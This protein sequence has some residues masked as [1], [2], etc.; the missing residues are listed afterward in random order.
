M[1]PLTDPA[2]SSALIAAIQWLQGALLGSVAI[3]T[4][5]ISVA[6]VGLLMLSGRI[7]Y[8]RGVTVILG[9]FII[10]GSPIIANGIRSSILSGGAAGGYA[11]L[12]TDPPLLAVPAPPQSGYDP[13]AGASVP[14]R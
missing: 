4:A 14:A 13:Y 7:D 8:R 11:G 3:A 1:I 10:F 6:S 9:C 12:Q 5:I 2:G